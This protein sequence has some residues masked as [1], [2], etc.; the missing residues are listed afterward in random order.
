[1]RVGRESLGRRSPPTES[2]SR[3]KAR[4]RERRDSERKHE[5]LFL[6]FFL[7]IFSHSYF[8]SNK[9][10][11]RLVQI[12]IQIRGG[13]TR[14]AHIK[15]TDPCDS[16]GSGR[17]RSVGTGPAGNVYGFTRFGRVGC[18]WFNTTRRSPNPN[19]HN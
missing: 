15:P 9:T 4:V 3:E 10:I 19:R 13:Q 16:V 14:S 2:R 6:P 11:L 7:I 8:F 5:F 18:G 1:V 17:V 12:R